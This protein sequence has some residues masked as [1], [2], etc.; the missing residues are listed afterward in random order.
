MDWTDGLENCVVRYDY[1]RST[2][3]FPVSWGRVLPILAVQYETPS[4]RRK[5]V[6]SSQDNSPTGVVG[7]IQRTSEAAQTFAALNNSSTYANPIILYGSKILSV[8][9]K[10]LISHAVFV[11][12]ERSRQPFH[13]SASRF[14]L[15]PPP[16]PSLA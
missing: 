1:E 16:P 2:E 5:T 8:S 13:L 10:S 14:A 12:D 9:E 6:S 3:S 4:K 7:Q 15:A 11:K